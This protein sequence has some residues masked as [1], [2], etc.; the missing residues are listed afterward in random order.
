MTYKHRK[1]KLFYQKTIRTNLK[2]RN[3][4]DIRSISLKVV[5]QYT[6]KQS[7]NYKRKLL[8]HKLSIFSRIKSETDPHIWRRQGDMEERDGPLQIGRWQTSNQEGFTYEAHFGQL[9]G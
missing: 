9:Q 4:L 1:P 2:I 5:F 3:L 7:E 6:N 8:I